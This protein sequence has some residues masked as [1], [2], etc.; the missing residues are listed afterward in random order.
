MGAMDQVGR[1]LQEAVFDESR[2][3]ELAASIDSA[4]ELIGSQLCVVAADV[5]DT[6]PDFRF[7]RG[8]IRGEPQEDLESEYIEHYHS[9]DEHVPRMRLMRFGRLYHNT[10]LL[11][12]SEQKSSPV[13]AGFIPRHT[14][15]D[16][17]NIRMPGHGGTS[18]FWVVAREMDRGGWSFE[19][20]KRIELLVPHVAHFVRVRQALAAADAR[21]DA[22]A[23]L[24][25][26][27]GLGV[28]HLDRHGRVLEAN[29]RARRVLAEGDCLTQR[30][31]QLRARARHE[32]ARLGRLLT[33]CLDRGVGGSMA[34]W[35]PG[36]GRADSL[37]LHVCPVRPDWTSFD[38]RGVVV[39]VLLVE[40][41]RT[42][43]MDARQLA[44]VYDLT[45]AESRVA[46]LLAEGQSVGEV[47]ASTGRTES[48]VRWH[49]KNL[50]SK[51]DVHR[52]ADL[53]RLV[54]STAAAAPTD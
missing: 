19:N 31:N 10:D 38:T 28:L 9:L 2:W 4:C 13:Y 21:G 33:A 25:D 14:S 34:L 43:G 20:L 27:T 29:E 7:N 42:P 53:V 47:A 52:Q 36:D 39:Q 32:D 24:L 1:L 18:M 12:E 26:R 45:A 40:P 11:T 41:G 22:L 35:R 3:P 54:L 49:V 5:D 37:I 17:F 46:L 48:T 44:E 16:Q 8:L 23:A 6:V 50:H 30:K 15:N 51:L